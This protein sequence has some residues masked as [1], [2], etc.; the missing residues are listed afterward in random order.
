VACCAIVS[1][2]RNFHLPLT[3]ALHAELRALAEQ[4]GQPATKLATEFVRQ[5]LAE[6][7]R[8]RRRERIGAYAAAVAGTQDDLDE[9]LEDASI[10]AL[11][12]LA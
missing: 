10:D 4:T 6:L 3:E 8:V 12:D 11:R 7:A 5:G 2:R 9:E 1:A